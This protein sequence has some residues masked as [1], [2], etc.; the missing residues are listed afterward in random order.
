MLTLLEIRDRLERYCI[1]R[2]AREAQMPYNTVYRLARG[3]V[4]NPS[5]ETLAKLSAYLTENGE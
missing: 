4:T 3:K 2:A 1:A 5:Y